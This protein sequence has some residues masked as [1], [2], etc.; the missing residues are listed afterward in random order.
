METR[1]SRSPIIRQMER[2]WMMATDKARARNT[3]DPLKDIL[4]P[5]MPKKLSNLPCTEEEFT[6]LFWGSVWMAVND[7]GDTSEISTL[8][9]ATAYRELLYY[10]DVDIEQIERRTTMST[11]RSPTGKRDHIVNEQ[12]LFGSVSLCGEKM[13][14]W[15]YSSAE[16]ANLCGR[17]E[18]VFKMRA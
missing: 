1:T 16:D 11:K 4:S 12:Y 18:R 7:G 13:N 14:D 17:C 6:N 9:R 2:G 15:Y 5:A 10:A 3:L 8:E